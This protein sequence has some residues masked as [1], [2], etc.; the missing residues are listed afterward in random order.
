[1]WGTKTNP[2]LEERVLFLFSFLT[3]LKRAFKFCICIFPVFNNIWEL[4]AWLQEQG[5]KVKLYIRKPGAKMQELDAAPSLER[6]SFL[7]AS[8][9]FHLE[10]GRD[11]KLQGSERWERMLWGLVIKSST[12]ENGDC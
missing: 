11:I 3:S 5:L 6:M 1:M 7:T 12:S 10:A 8:Y 2:S 9:N 4:T